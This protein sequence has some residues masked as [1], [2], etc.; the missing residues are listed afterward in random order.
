MY[1]QINVQVVV[2]DVT[3]EGMGGIVLVFDFISV[4]IVQVYWDKLYFQSTV[5]FFPQV[6]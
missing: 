1:F 6:K 4:H 2:N 5:S 3:T